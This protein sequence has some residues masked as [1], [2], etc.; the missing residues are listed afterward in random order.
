[1]AIATNPVPETWAATSPAD[2]PPHLLC[3][4]D[5]PCIALTATLDLAAAM[6]RDSSAWRGALGGQTLACFFD[7][8]TTGMTVATGT[9]ADWLG[10]LPLVLPRDELG[11]DDD[12]TIEDMARALSAT[13]AALFAHTVPHRLL[14]RIAAG[15]TVP[16]VNGKS[17]Q[18]RPCQAV[19]D[20]LTLRE[21]FGSLEGVALAFVGDAHNATVHSLME[22]GALAG[23]DV[24]ICCPPDCRPD[25][26]VDLGARVIA[27]LHGAR[28]RITDDVADGVRGAD[29]VYTHGWSVTD[30]DGRRRLRSYRVGLDVMRLAD[31]HAVFMHCL[32]AHR[33]ME[34]DA[35]ILDGRR[36]IVW[37]QA[38]N[39]LP[40]EQALL[41]SLITASQAR[42]AR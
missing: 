23:M 13:A 16:L 1:M 33:G 4:A 6:K 35:R 32:P 17:D 10:M 42:D 19:A 5:L 38:A 18:H 29:A 22:A 40:A 2:W 21:R 9:A 41:Y 25:R 36:S 34:V 20:L 14:R 15:A 37:E 8:P 31:P 3:V 39:R 12:D 7:P 24:R 28:L 30:G 11:L 27:D 26:L